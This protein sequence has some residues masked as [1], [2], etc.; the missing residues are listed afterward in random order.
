MNFGMD[1]TNE[2]KNILKKAVSDERMINY[3]NLLFKI[4]DPIMKNFGFFKRFGTLHD[5]LINFL[6][7]EMRT[8]KGI[9]EQK[10]MLNKIEELR[11]LIY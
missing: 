2:R 9:K 7:E 6:N 4:G 1:F 3:N 11:D 8:N 5:L 10:E